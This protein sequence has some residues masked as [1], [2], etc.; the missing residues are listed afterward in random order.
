ME[1]SETEKLGSNHLQIVDRI[2][3]ENQSHVKRPMNAFMVWSRIQRKKLANLHPK[4][5]NSEISKKLGVEWK[6]LTESQKRPFIDEA[7]RLRVQHMIDH[8]EY[9]YRPRR[10]AKEGKTEKPTDKSDDSVKSS[11]PTEDRRD[12]N[13]LSLP[14]PS[15]HPTPSFPPFHAAFPVSF[16]SYGSNSTSAFHFRSAAVDESYLNAYNWLITANRKFPFSSN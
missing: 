4:M 16:P 14:V 2:K 3:R 6:K 9:K 8:P 1:Y 15:L 11:P 13:V 10:K 7:K 5:H 12:E